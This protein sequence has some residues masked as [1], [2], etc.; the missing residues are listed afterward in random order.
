MVSNL[1]SLEF[2]YGGSFGCDGTAP[3][4]TTCSEENGSE[5]DNRPKFTATYQPN[6]NLTLF[7]VS[8]AGYRP[9]GNNAALP[10][11]CANDPEASFFPKKIYLG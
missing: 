5:S 11:F 6:E 10:Y 2:F 7:A 4:G 9:G 8:S 3:E 1:Q